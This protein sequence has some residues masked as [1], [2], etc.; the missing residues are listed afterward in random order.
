[1]IS[2]YVMIR[3]AV[4][5]EKDVKEQTIMYLPKLE[6]MSTNEYFAFLDRATF[7]NFSGRTANAMTGTIF[8]RAWSLEGLNDELTAN[9]D[10]FSRLGQSFGIF[11]AYAAKEIIKMGRFGVLLDLPEAESPSPQPYCVGY[12]AE[13]ILDWEEDEVDGRIQ[14]VMVVL[15]E[16]R[17]VRGATGTKAKYVPL[18]RKLYLTGT[19]TNR[20]Y[21]QETYSHD[22]E[23]AT[24]EEKYLTSR[25][26]PIVRGKA[27]NYIPF[28]VFG[29]FESTMTIEKPPLQ[30]ICR[31][32]LSHYRSYGQLEHGRFFCGNPQ[33]FVESPMG[34]GETTDKFTL[35]SSYVWVTPAGARPGILEMNGQGLKFLENAL[36]QKEQQA[37]SLGGR[38]IGVRG[39]ATSES[40]N[41][42]K[43]SER[44]E[45]S[46]LLE[47]TKSL[48]AGWTQLL[49][50]WAVWQDLSPA[51]AEK[52]TV[53]FNKDFLFDGIG[54]REFRA[55]HAMYK[56]GV[57]PI[58]VVYHYLKKS[59]VI[60]D[61]MSIKE[62][63]DLLDKME[64][65]PN[66]ADISSRM[67]G[68]PDAKSEQQV[69]EA[70]LDRD[71]QIELLDMKLNGSADDIALQAKVDL[72]AA[73]KA[74]KS[75]EKI[76]KSQPKV[77]AGPAKSAAGQPA[78]QPAK[79]VLKK[80]A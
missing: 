66:N 44:N 37:A 49:K 32:N 58:D 12:T 31:M 40:D 36:D 9:L 61:W 14:L 54:A 69:E 59:S 51:L 70:V 41:Q 11:S 67:E 7:Y 39:Q 45:Q 80:P 29:A 24:L 33:Y 62:F 3:D 75:A 5:G 10:N 72:V 28:H 57:V 21:V 76:A 30:D 35:G 53:E 50:W 2:E 13:H 6:G 68:F 46:V 20:E 71:L 42:L 17:T 64:S 55:I 16:I 1:M 22:S 65:F 52:I 48:D 60:P 18:Y 23:P 63:K 43:L 74:A 27:L 77:V 38:M 73:D 15:R 4:A 56:D 8:R 34:G 78:K 25:V 26:T 19:D 47:I 79:T